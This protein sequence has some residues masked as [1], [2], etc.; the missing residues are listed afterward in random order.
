MS[1]P[2]PNNLVNFQG[3]N[4]DKAGEFLEKSGKIQPVR[5]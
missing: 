2:F 1:I 5:A 3:E 4:L